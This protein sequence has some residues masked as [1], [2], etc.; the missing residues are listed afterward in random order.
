[1][2]SETNHD[3]KDAAGNGL[4]RLARRP[5]LWAMLSLVMTGLAIYFHNQGAG[6]FALTLGV[7]VLALAAIAFLAWSLGASGSASRLL[8][9]AADG[10]DDGIMIVAPDGRFEYA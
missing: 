2:G 5:M 3:I 1:M 9:T 6:A 4:L 7:S 8:R 10:S